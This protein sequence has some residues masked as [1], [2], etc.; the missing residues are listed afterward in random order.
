MK[1]ITGLS[2]SEVEQCFSIL[3]SVFD[4]SF[5]PKP[6]PMEQLKVFIQQDEAK[7]DGKSGENSD[8][9]PQGLLEIPI[10]E[11]LVK[12]S[13]NGNSGING[14]L[15]TGDAS[16]EYSKT[17]KIASEEASGHDHLALSVEIIENSNSS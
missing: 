5:K 3:Y 17:Q 1:E 11:K 15:S 6:E 7:V 4:S 14:V 9:Q 10:D 2:E 12:A 16:H 8:I 13:I